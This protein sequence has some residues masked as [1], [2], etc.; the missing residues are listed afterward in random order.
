MWQKSSHCDLQ[1]NKTDNKVTRTH[2]TN[3]QQHTQTCNH[4]IQLHSL[5]KFLFKSKRDHTSIS[6]FVNEQTSNIQRQ[7]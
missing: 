6:L 1:Q 4:V 2:V 7:W 3:T 5:F